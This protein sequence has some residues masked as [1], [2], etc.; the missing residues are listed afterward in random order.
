MII[1]EFVGIFHSM[2]PLVLP[3]NFK[4]KY[5]FWCSNPNKESHTP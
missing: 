3:N 4:L 5:F 2:A 1:F